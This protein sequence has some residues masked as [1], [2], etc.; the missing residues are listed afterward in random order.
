[1]RE[2]RFWRS[3]STERR[4]KSANAHDLLDRNQPVVNLGNLHFEQPFEEFGRRTRKHDQRRVVAHFDAGN[5]RL[6]RISLAEKIARDL[7][8]LG[9]HQFVV[10]VVEDQH[11]FFPHLI[12]LAGDN[13]AHLVLVLFVQVGLL[14]LHDARSEVLAQRQYRTPAEVGQFDLVGN[15]LAHLV[16]RVDLAGVGQRNLL[17]GILHLAVLDDRAVPP[18]F[19]VAFLGVDDHVEILVGLIGLDQQVAEHVLQHT[20]HRA[21]VDI[22][23][24]FE[25]RKSAYQIEVV[26]NCNLF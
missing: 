26:H 2:A 23:K 9:H 25:L 14:Q 13:F 11:L 15:L 4:P 17:V 20:D 22:L 16:G 24:L 21:L 18:D 8:G 5:D 6:D 12:N 19:E 1:M 10:L 3:D 7:L